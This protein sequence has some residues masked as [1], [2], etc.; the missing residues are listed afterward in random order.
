[1]NWCITQL[2]WC[3]AEVVIG[4]WCEHTYNWWS[5]LSTAIAPEC[6]LYQPVEGLPQ[7]AILC[8][9][10]CAIHNSLMPY[11]PKVTML[12][13]FVSECQGLHLTWLNGES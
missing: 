5:S 3:A 10:F 13:C 11:I 4:D 2:N 12:Y 1:M 6:A 9:R 7:N 8:H